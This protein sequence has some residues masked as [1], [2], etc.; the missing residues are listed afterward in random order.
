VRPATWGESF[1]SMTSCQQRINKHSEEN[2][3]SIAKPKRRC[4]NLGSWI[5]DTSISRMAKFPSFCLLLES[6]ELDRLLESCSQ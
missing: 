3:E 1:A 2:V 4:E 6:Y 5:Y